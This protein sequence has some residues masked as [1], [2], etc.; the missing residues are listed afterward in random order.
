MHDGGPP[1]PSIERVATGIRGVDTILGGGFLAGSVQLL[2]GRPGSGKTIFANQVA[3][4]HASAGHTAAYVTLLAESHARMLSH[5]ASFAFFDPQLVSRRII[6]MSGYS[7]LEQTGL[8]GLLDLLTRTIREQGASLLVIDG[9]STAKE[10]APTTTAFKRFLLRLSTSASLTTCTILLVSPML[11]SS[12]SQP[13]NATVDGI[14]RIDKRAC[15]ARVMREMVVEKMRGTDY[16]LGVHAIDIDTR[17]MHVYPRIESLPIRPTVTVAH[18]RRLEFGIPGLDAMLGGGVL[19]GSTTG[20]VGPTGTGKTLLGSSFLARGLEQGERAIYAGLREMP[21]QVIQQAEAVGLRLA[22][23]MARGMLDVLWFP[24]K[25]ISI[26]AIAWRL[27]DKIE[28]GGIKRV[29]IDGIDGFQAM[30]AY[31]E[32]LLRF[33]TALV[34]RLAALGATTVMTEASW[35]APTGLE[36]VASTS[37]NN[38]LVLDEASSGRHVRR[39]IETL[40]VQAGPHDM[41]PRRIHISNKG[42]SVDRPLRGRLRGDKP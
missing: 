23:P 37:V 41:A 29:V 8:D 34:T 20:I 11:R 6:Y 39:T 21:E 16:A 4:H 38:L 28:Q 1:Q 30:L 13:E 14:V 32:R 25:E 42:L 12:S 9:L 17:G 5:L 3:F 18:R 33:Y 24:A 15:G 31:P 19:E 27:L 36:T 22:E 26:D 2:L 40:K 35:A 10:F 7:V